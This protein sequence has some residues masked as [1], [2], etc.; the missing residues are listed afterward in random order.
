ML[1]IRDVI[2]EE[3]DDVHNGL[4][5]RIDPQGVRPQLFDPKVDE[6]MSIS[7]EIVMCKRFI[8]DDGEEIILGCSEY[9]Q[10]ILGVWVESYANLEKT[11]KTQKDNIR[12]LKTII[13]HDEVKLRIQKERIDNLNKKILNISYL[14]VAVGIVCILALIMGVL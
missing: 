4:C 6:T 10:G 7:E 12:H 9:A 8:R 5:H 3:Y 11:I 14:L 1:M 2:I 13:S